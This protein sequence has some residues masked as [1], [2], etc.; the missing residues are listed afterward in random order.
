MVIDEL[1]LAFEELN[2]KLHF[3]KHPLYLNE[4]FEFS[5]NE[6]VLVEPKEENLKS[7]NCTN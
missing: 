3:N 4:M 1:I 2:I 6:I 7:L 5:L